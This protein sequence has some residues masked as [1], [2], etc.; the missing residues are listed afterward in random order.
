MHGSLILD[1]MEQ[2]QGLVGVTLY[3]A[4]A[5]DL[6]HPFF[7]VLEG[8][9]GARLLP[10]EGEDLGARMSGAMQKAFSLGH[11]RVILIGTDL[12]NLTRRHLSEAVNDLGS[13]DLVLGPTLDGGYYLIALS[14]PVPELFCGLAWSTT[15]VLEET[16]KKAASLK[17]SVTLL[18][19]LRDLDDLEDLNAFIK[20]AGKDKSLSKRTAGALTLIGERLKDRQE[21]SQK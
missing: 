18:R 11:R 17:L 13:H 4:G 5:P 6:A 3:V 14:R 9:Y 1:A 7:K 19:S 15:T 12:P 8:R 16:K 2:A 20:L 10:Q 21:T